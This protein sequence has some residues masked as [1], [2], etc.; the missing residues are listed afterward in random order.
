LS[1]VT[2]F[3][4]L[5]FAILALVLVMFGAL[6][7]VSFLLPADQVRDAVKAEIRAVTGLDPVLRGETRVSLFPTGS[8]SLSDVVLGDAGASDPPLAAEQLSARLRFFP[9]LFGRIEVSDVALV[10]P[11][12]ALILHK[13][14]SSNWSPLLA[15]LTRNFDPRTKSADRAMSFSEILI[16][17]GTIWL[18]DEARGVTERLRDV[19]VSLA[20]PAISKSFAA[21]G[22]LTWRYEPMDVSLTLAD[23]AAALRG[24]RSGLKLRVAGPPLKAAFDGAIGSH[25]TLKI[26]GALAVDSS[27][28]RRAMVWAG[29]QP[30]PGGGF[31][32]FSLKAQTNVVAGTVALTQVALE[33]DG[34]AAEG[35]LT[36]A[37]NGRQ[38]VQGTLAAD[39]IDLTPYLSTIRLLAANDRE[40][41]RAPLDLDGLIA[42]ELDLRLSAGKMTI[43]SAKLGRTAIAANLRGGRMT[44]T[45]GE[46]QAFGGV[47]KGSLGLAASERG[48]DFRSQLQFSNVNLEA[49]IG[50]LFGIRRLEGKGDFSITLDGSGPNIHAL[51]RTLNGSAKLTGAKGAMTG[52]NIEQLLRRLERRPLSGG[53]EFRTGRTPFE[54]LGIDVRIANGTANVEGMTLEGPSIRLS[55]NGLASIP[56]RDLDLKGIA[57]LLGSASAFELPFVVQGQWDDPVMLPDPQI[58]I[59]R[60]GAAAPLLDAVRDRRA[61]EAVRSAIGRLGEHGAT[62]AEPGETLSPVSGT[63]DETSGAQPPSDN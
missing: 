43:G 21:T 44:V 25:P 4:R 34:N 37:S 57:T 11:R 12:I 61:R 60:S 5:G 48:A 50:E 20:W 27:S 49:C 19:D 52:L 32:K 14:G 7:V 6:A 38:T 62:P 26:D 13:D 55:L 1:A 10:N 56:A 17:G 45:I 63:Q 39:E 36:L 15:S 29:Q 3:K 46:S 18:E 51:T 33:L 53:S 31:G 54:T 41:N 59:R 40:W 30:L 9:L 35:V 2:G 47:I 8:V 23:F 24:E 16:T 58:L 42:N 28:L 22:K